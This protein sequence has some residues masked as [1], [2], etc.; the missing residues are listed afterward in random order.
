MARDEARILLIGLSESGK[1]SLLEAVKGAYVKGHR[2]APPD[3]IPVTIGM[4]LLKIAV[5][6]M[7]VTLWDVGGTMRKIWPQYYGEADGVVFVVDASDRQQ[8]GES[9]EALREILQNTATCPVL[10]LANKQD[11]PHAARASEVIDAICKPA[12][13]GV[14][15]TPR[16]YRVMEIS[17]LKSNS[18]ESK[19]FLEWIVREARAGA[20]ERQ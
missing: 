12:G 3:A 18:G 5:M 14:K 7:D 4:N 17:A 8:F 1:T 16:L 10:V 11:L 20:L 15:E 13:L 6:D 2:I 19:E 9:C